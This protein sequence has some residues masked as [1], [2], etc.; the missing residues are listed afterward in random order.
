M[1][2]EF[3]RIR[4]RGGEGSSTS[5]ES[6]RGGFGGWRCSHSLLAGAGRGP[7]ARGAE[8]SRGALHSSQWGCGMGGGA[9]RAAGG[10]QLRSSLSVGVRRDH[11]QVIHVHVVERRQ[12]YGGYGDMGKTG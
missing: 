2:E 11:E 1:K 7:Q 10:S 12:G 8:E 3:L 4:G 5:A 6:E 9:G